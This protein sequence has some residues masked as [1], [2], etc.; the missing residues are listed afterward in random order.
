[1]EKP[2]LSTQY[3]KFTEPQKEGTV[4][5]R[6]KKFTYGNTHYHHANSSIIPPFKYT[7]LVT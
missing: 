7:K 6:A 1:M 5:A 2:D 3:I 4:I